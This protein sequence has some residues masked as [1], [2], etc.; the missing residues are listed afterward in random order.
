[1]KY[2]DRIDETTQGKINSNMRCIEIGRVCDICRER[3]EINSNMRC[4]EIKAYEKCVPISY[5]INSNMRC[6]E[7]KVCFQHSYLQL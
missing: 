6:I 5:V 1:M 7:I 2:L 4:I 3:A